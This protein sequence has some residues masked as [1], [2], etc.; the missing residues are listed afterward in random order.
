MALII[1]NIFLAI[2]VVGL[3]Y[4]YIE[5]RDLHEREGIPDLV[6]IE[7]LSAVFD[8]AEGYSEPHARE[9][10]NEAEA[11]A[12]VMGLDEATIFSLRIAALLHDCGQAQIPREIFKKRRELSSD[13]WFIVKTHPL[14]GEMALRKS[15]PAHD[16]VPSLIRWHH[17]RWDGTGYPDRLEGDE[18]PVAARILAVV[19]AANAMS[20]ERPYRSAWNA[21]RIDKELE[22]MAGLM[23]DPK[24]IRGR[25]KA[26]EQRSK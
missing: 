21:N 1:I 15:L 14:L 11:I 16:E 13:D 3:T 2:A 22:K 19:D 26:R 7:G 20:R 4:K 6:Y 18:I 17:E 8:A 23:F 5:L 10:A 12:R 9:M 25:I 24:V